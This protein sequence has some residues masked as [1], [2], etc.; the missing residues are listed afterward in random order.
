M[1]RVRHVALCVVILCAGCRALA[2]GAASPDALMRQAQ[3]QFDVGHGREAV[4][5]YDAAAKAFAAAGD[6]R[7]QTRALQQSGETS[8]LMGEPAKA[9]PSLAQALA[10]DPSLVAHIDATAAGLAAR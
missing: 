5:L 4:S 6:L 8:K 9:T 2:Q 10:L 7:A 3:A 1:V